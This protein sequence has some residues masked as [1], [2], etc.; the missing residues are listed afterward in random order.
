[1]RKIILLLSILSFAIFSCDPDLGRHH[2]GFWYIKNSSNKIIN[3]HGYYKTNDVVPAQQSWNIA[4]SPDS[5]LLYST[6]GME[7]NSTDLFNC[8]TIKSTDSIKLFVNEAEVLTWRKSEKDLGRRN[9]FR[10]S[11]WECKKRHIYDEYYEYTWTFV[12]TDEDIE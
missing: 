8:L 12:I 9:F 1:M 10:E 5:S 2:D 3:I 6:G 11:S 4:L 7:V